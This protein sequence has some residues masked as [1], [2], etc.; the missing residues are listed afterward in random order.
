MRQ[1]PRHRWLFYF[2]LFFGAVSFRACKKEPPPSFD[3][4]TPQSPGPFEPS[5]AQLVEGESYNHQVNDDVA[6]CAS[7]HPHHV[8]DWQSSAHAFSSFNNP[9]YRVAFDDYVKEAGQEK[10]AFCGGC[11]DPSLLFAGALKKTVQPNDARGHVGVSCN[12]CH[13]I[14]SITFDGVGSYHLST[15]PIPLPREND[16]ASL[17]AHIK[18]VGKPVLKTNEFGKDFP[19]GINNQT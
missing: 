3:I 13:G 16:A 4:T 19:L 8:Q 12:G 11:H 7:C 14:E 2:L 15:A 1:V 9:L 18:R 10:A 17:E 5:F 6:V